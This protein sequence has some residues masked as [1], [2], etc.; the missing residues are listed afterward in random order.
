M[1]PLVIRPNQEWDLEWAGGAIG[2][3]RRRGCCNV[4][5]SNLEPKT[6]LKCYDGADSHTSTF[7]PRIGHRRCSRSV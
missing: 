2:I 4:G 1:N 7:H 5:R 6:T 3:G